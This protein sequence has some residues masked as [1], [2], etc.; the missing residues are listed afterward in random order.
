MTLAIYS[1]GREGKPCNLWGFLWLFGVLGCLYCPGVLLT[2]AKLWDSVTNVD[3]YK[4]LSKTW[5]AL[6]SFF[7]EQQQQQQQTLIRINS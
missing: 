7:I 1:G 4:L 5:D 2:S 3:S 6:V